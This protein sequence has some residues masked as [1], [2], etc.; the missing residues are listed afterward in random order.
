MNDV[1]IVV[2]GVGLALPGVST[3][4]QIVAGPAAA[5]SPVD[6]AERLGRKGLRYKD[7]ATCLSLAAARDALAEAGLAAVGGD[8]DDSTG[9]VVS[10]NFGNVETVCRAAVTIGE[11]GS[12]SLSPMDIPNASSNIT[13]SEIAIRFGLRGPNLT[14]CNGATSG[15]DAVRWGSTVLR[16]GRADAMVI[17]GV[18]P[19]DAM[20]RDLT[21]QDRV[22]DGAVALVLETERHA[23]DREISIAAVL[24]R[25]VRRADFATCEAELRRA[26]GTVPALLLTPDDGE[27]PA[28][29]PVHRLSAQWG[30]SSGALGVLQCAA[31]IGRFADGVTGEIHA[32]AGEDD[33]VAAAALR[34]ATS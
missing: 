33:A 20:M 29:V 3:V 8:F 27:S 28:H 14:L 23:V 11:T 1:T 34:R 24:S 4:D 6:P 26:T 15:L 16:A 25:Q 7:R 10:T 31:A 19:G 12:R 32:F 5:A 17:V 30:A 9:V 22:L 18:E 21:G 2:T 13:A